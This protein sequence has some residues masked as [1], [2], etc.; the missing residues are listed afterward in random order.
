MGLSRPT[1]RKQRG[2]GS[3]FCSTSCFVK[4]QQHFRFS[5]NVEVVDTEASIIR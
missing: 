4:F 3:G 1:K 5:S 2:L